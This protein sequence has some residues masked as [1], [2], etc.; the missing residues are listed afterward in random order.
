MR[1]CCS[2][3]CWSWLDRALFCT[4]ALPHAS[5]V[6]L[7][8]HALLIH[9]LF[10]PQKRGWVREGGGARE[11]RGCVPASVP[12]SL[13]PLQAVNQDFSCTGTLV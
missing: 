1:W 9:H 5:M 10:E 6:L 13:P 2:Q 8:F 12:W 7:P 3:C 4:D 11:G